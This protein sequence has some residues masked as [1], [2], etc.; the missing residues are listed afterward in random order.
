MTVYIN[1]LDLY[2]ALQLCKIFKLLKKI[3][4][5]LP[6]FLWLYFIRTWICHSSTV[7][8]HLFGRE[9]LGIIGTDILWILT[10]QLKEIESSDPTSSFTHS[11]S[12]ADF[13]GKGCW[14]IYTSSAVLLSLKLLTIMNTARKCDAVVSWSVCETSKLVWFTHYRIFCKPVLE[15]MT[16]SWHMV[17]VVFPVQ[18][19]DN[20]YRFIGFFVQ[21]LH[22]RVLFLQHIH[23]YHFVWKTAS[24]LWK[25]DNCINHIL[26]SCITVI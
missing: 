1:S 13:M 9:L 7:F 24:W 10:N 19:N 11:S 2:T 4:T 23:K 8:L 15:T 3:A 22:L 12:I 5:C 18:Q 16:V 26:L 14:S 6:Q 20:A 25:L 17:S 21:S